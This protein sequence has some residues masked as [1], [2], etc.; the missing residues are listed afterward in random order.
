MRFLCDID[1]EGNIN[2][3]TA[4]SSFDHGELFGR[5]FQSLKSIQQEQNEKIELY[6]KRYLHLLVQLTLIRP[7]L[8]ISFLDLYAT[9]SSIEKLQI[10]YNNNNNSNSTSTDN[11][12][13]NNGSNNIND[14]PP[15]NTFEEKVRLLPNDCGT[16]IRKI[17]YNEV[18]NI[19][20]VITT[21]AKATDSV[22]DTLLQ[23]EPLSL[24]LLI[25][26]LEII[27]N[28]PQIP[29]SDHMVNMVTSYYNNLPVENKDIRLLIPILGG[30]SKD[31]IE[32]IFP[33]LILNL[34]DTNLNENNL[35]N[36]TTTPTTNGKIITKL[37][38]IKQ[39]IIRITHARPPPLSRS[40]LFVLLHY[41]PHE[42]YKIELKLLLEII[43][44]CLNLTDEFNSEIIKE[45][46]NIILTNYSNP[47][48]KY[49]NT[50]PTSYMRTV[51]ISSQLFYD[52]RKHALQFIIPNLIKLKIWN[53][54]NKIFDGVIY[55]IKA[56]L[57]NYK[58]SNEIDN[59]LKLILCLPLTQLRF[60]IKGIPVISTL[61]SKLLKVLNNSNSS[62]NSNSNSLNLINN[63]ELN[64]IIKGK[65]GGLEEENYEAQY[66]DKLKLLNDLLIFS[67]EK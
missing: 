58:N 18:L 3:S 56:L 60:L 66:Q 28:D 31:Q 25:S 34:K 54:P 16:T 8:L 5:K 7:H 15:T 42:K 53:N 2:L 27:L 38:Y 23:S 50:I 33:Y 48:S 26:V 46:L 39:C 62:N 55:G 47:T 19:I 12:S 4:L 32:E 14:S 24:P 1:F 17:I 35:S 21:S 6:A 13:N 36:T 65:W 51:I 20:P 41:I 59:L 61:F 43:H 52:I 44:L 64:D 9:I 22:F 11:N 67:E 29:A 45:S 49:H 30:M 10:D 37:D 57:N 63:P 40:H